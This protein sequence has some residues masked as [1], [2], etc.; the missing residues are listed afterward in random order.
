MLFDELETEIVTFFENNKDNMDTCEFL[1]P[2]VLD[3]MIKNNKVRIK[4]LPTTATWYGVTYKEDAPQVR[5]SI[6]KLVKTKDN[7]EG[8]YPLHLWGE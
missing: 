8:D 2:D 1:L 3:E 4:V 5:E 7:E 6:K